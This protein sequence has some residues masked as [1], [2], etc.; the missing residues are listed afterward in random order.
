MN[1]KS[2]THTQKRA[3]ATHELC[4]FLISH[5]FNVFGGPPI[6]CHRTHTHT[7]SPVRMH[8]ITQT[9]TPLETMGS[10]GVRGEIL[11]THG[12]LFVCVCVENN[13]IS[14]IYR[15][16]CSSERAVVVASAMLFRSHSLVRSCRLWLLRHSIAIAVAVSWC[17]L[18][19]FG[20]SR[21][22]TD[23]T[24]LVDIREQSYACSNN[25][26]GLSVSFT[27]HLLQE[28]QKF[29]KRFGRRTLSCA[30]DLVF[31]QYSS[32]CFLLF[33]FRK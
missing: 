16:V 5:M 31:H 2:T 23:F 28:R 12:P 11:S 26:V 30:Y 24:H 29:V 22:D 33:F 6:P 21:S 13:N 18:Y 3:R 8:G 19:V 10:F 15:I 25:S 9:Q 32:R 14:R 17:A 27:E 4:D 7:L 20:L 1:R